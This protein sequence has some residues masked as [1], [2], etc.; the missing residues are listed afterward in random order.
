MKQIKRNFFGRWES[1]FKSFF[2]RCIL[3]VSFRLD[4]LMINFLRL[5]GLTRWHVS[6][7][8][9]LMLAPNSSNIF[10]AVSSNELSVTVSGM[11]TISRHSCLVSYSL[12][13]DFRLAWTCSLVG[14][15]R[16]AIWIKILSMSYLLDFTSYSNLHIHPARSFPQN[17][18]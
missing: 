18:T 15:L 11:R 7:S 13:Q 12:F 17:S 16:V 5:D 3:A 1:D 14:F 8:A 2:A 9:G 10:S 6:M 4:I